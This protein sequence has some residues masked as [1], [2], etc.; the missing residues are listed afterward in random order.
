M[1][2]FESWI[3]RFR[4]CVHFVHDKMDSAAYYILG[5]ENV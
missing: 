5:L 3:N 2:L 1:I 4:K